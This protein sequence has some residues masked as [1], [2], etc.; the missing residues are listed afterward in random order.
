VERA[1]RKTLR[2][3][4][5]AELRLFAEDGKA[6][7]LRLGGSSKLSQIEVLSERKQGE[8]GEQPPSV[9]EKVCKV[10]ENAC[11]DLAGERQCAAQ[12]HLGYTANSPSGR[13]DRENDAAGCLQGRGEKA[14]DGKTYRRSHRKGKIKQKRIYHGVH[15]DSWS[16]V[17][18]AL[19]AEAL[20]KQAGADPDELVDSEVSGDSPV[21]LAEGNDRDDPGD[22]IDPVTL[23]RP[24]DPAD[25]DVSL[26]HRDSTRDYI[27]DL[28]RLADHDAITLYVGRSFAADV[29]AP[30]S[31]QLMADSLKH[32]LYASDPDLPD[33]KR[34]DV[35]DALA[36]AYAPGHLGSIAR[37][38]ARQHKREHGDNSDPNAQSDFAERLRSGIRRGRDP[39]EFLTQS[40]GALAF[41]LRKRAKGQVQVVTTNYHDKVTADEKK[42]QT[43]FPGLTGCSFAPRPLHQF[44][45]ETTDEQSIPLYSLNGL[46]RQDPDGS[47]P[48]LVIGEADRFVQY[49]SQ[50]RPIE[51]YADPRINLMEE[52][53]RNSVCIFVGSNLTNPDILAMLARTKYEQPRYAIIQSRDLGLENFD[54]RARAQNLVA[55]RF[56]HLDVVP[57]IIDFSHQA[58][59]LLIEVALR[60]QEEAEYR[61][62]GERLDDWWGEW[63]K[64]FGFKSRGKGKQAKRSE[65]HQRIWMTQLNRIREQIKKS[66]LGI[67]DEPSNGDEQERLRLDV[68]LR[69]PDERSLTLWATSDG[70]WLD[71]SSAPWC[72]IPDDVDRASKK[73]AVQQAFRSGKPVYASIDQTDD[74]G[75]WRCQLCIPLVLRGPEWH[76]LPVGVVRIV[77]N[78]GVTK[79]SKGNK[80]PEGELAR[81][82]WSPDFADELQELTGYVNSAVGDLLN[83]K[84]K[85]YETAS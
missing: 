7:W 37:E 69:H 26:F 39:G 54:D 15:Y 48:N 11:E 19:V 35:I 77:S 27:N 85:Y 71:S 83:R 25:F 70:I 13:I 47:K 78:M 9:V 62:Y 28:A 1:Q 80:Q 30:L 16:E 63:A 67:S 61:G 23:Y 36:R 20:I 44:G 18:L 49:D 75:M 4:V 66:H 17:T 64:D 46:V 68:W 10:I 12:A 14:M 22:H 58:P 74:G 34:K 82:E 5:A 60:L 31:D 2:Q 52:V 79:D 72:S 24:I 55:Q 29:T 57:I 84:S 42:V 59:Q 21:E 76:H 8:D 51:A 65:R 38:K 6:K 32:W 33:A 81:L 40:I 53:L 41:A 43:E 45:E 50:L 3:Q 56:L 73:H